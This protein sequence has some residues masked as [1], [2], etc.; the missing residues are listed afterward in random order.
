LVQG[1]RKKITLDVAV[2]FQSPTICHTARTP[3][4]TRY[5]GYLTNRKD[6]IGDFAAAGKETYDTGIPWKKADKQDSNGIMRLV[7]EPADREHCPVPV[8]IDYKDFFYTHARDGWNRLIL[9]NEAERQAYNYDPSQVKG[10]IVI[11][12]AACVPVK[13]QPGYLKAPGALASGRFEL[14]VNGKAV[15]KLVGIGAGTILLLGEKGSF[16]WE[17]NREGEFEIR[18]RVNEEDSHVRLSSIIIY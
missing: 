9:P 12:F 17:P 18:L 2:L 4:Q 1:S 5:L 6:K 14:Q 8:K 10:L 11:V 7:Y 3:S 16:H 13:C 15:Q